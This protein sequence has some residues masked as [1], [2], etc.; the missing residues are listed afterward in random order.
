MKHWCRKQ[1]CRGASAPPKVLIWWNSG[2]NPLKSGQNPFASGQNLWKPRQTPW[3]SEQTP[4]KYEQKWRPACFDLKKIAPKWHEE[5]CFLFAGFYSGTFGRIREKFLRTLKNLPAPTPMNWNLIMWRLR[6]LEQFKRALFSIELRCWL[7]LSWLW[8][9]FQGID[10]NYY[11]LRIL[12]STTLW[13]DLPMSVRL[14]KY[15]K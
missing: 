8:Q 5:F 2:K 11:C 7:N 12:D 10:C 15:A 14:T 3:K 6:D 4:W 13:L 1:R 9:I